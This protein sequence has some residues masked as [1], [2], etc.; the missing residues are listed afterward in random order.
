MKLTGHNIIVRDL[1]MEDAVSLAKYAN[2]H[3]IW[4]N[5]QDRF[6]HPYHVSD[7]QAWIA[8]CQ[9]DNVADQS[10]AIEKDGEVIGCVGCT[11]YDGER[12][13]VANVGYWIGEPFWGQGIASHVLGLYSD[14]LFTSPDVLRQ[15][16]QVYS[17][18]P[19]SCRV[20]EKNG[21]VREAS[22]KN[23][24]LKDGN[25]LDVFLYAKVKE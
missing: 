21:F 16:A 11:R 9:S 13:H 19:A 1:A 22:M 25:L 5:L 8:H 4:L 17:W 6:P 12:R 18:N 14:N 3:R 7:A 2:S 10:C 24:I 15:E 23:A 20:L